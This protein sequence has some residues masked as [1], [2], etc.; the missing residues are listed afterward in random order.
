MQ[1]DSSQNHTFK[2]P[3][4]ILDGVFAFPPNRD[5]L[6][7]TSYFIVENSGNILVDCPAWNEVNQQFILSQGGVRWLFFTHRGG[8]GKNV[9]LIQEF[10]GCE[11]LVQEQEAYLLPEATVTTFSLEYN[12]S[13]RSTALWTPG[14][15]P[16]STCLYYNTHGGVLFSGRHLLPNQEGKPVPLR[17][18]KTFHWFRQIRSIAALR[19][20]FSPQTLHYICPGANTGFLRG[21]GVIDQA[22]QHLSCLDLD[23]LRQVQAPLSV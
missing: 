12:L 14:Y 11:I 5:T 15:S 19:D 10:F 16:G 22:Y 8:M 23:N 2:P 4:S 17:T 20:R 7:A 18:A 6:G 9:A 3:R 13:D 1:S 21:K